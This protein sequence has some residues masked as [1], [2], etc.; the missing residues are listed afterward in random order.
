[1]AGA[2][3]VRHSAIAAGRP[4]KFT[5]ND[6]P[7]TPATARVKIAVGTFSKDFIRMISPNP[8]NSFSITARVASGVTSRIDGPVPPV[9]TINGSPSST[10]ARNVSSIVVRS[11]G[12]TRTWNFIS[13]S[14]NPRKTRSIS[15]PL[16]SS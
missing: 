15:G 3:S 4:G 16:A 5:I 14:K 13:S 10:M 8:G 11:S 2:I 12:S 6:R 7:A 9:V 1:M